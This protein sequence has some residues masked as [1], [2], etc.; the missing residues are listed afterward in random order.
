[1]EVFGGAAFLHKPACDLGLGGAS[2]SARERL[3]TL[4]RLG[5]ADVAFADSDYFN[6]WMATRFVAIWMTLLLDETGGDLDLAGA[7]TIAACG[8]PATRSVPRTCRW[9]I[10]CWRTSSG[11]R[12][13]LR[14]GTMLPTAAGSR[15]AVDRSA[16]APD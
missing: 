3:R 12:M 10:V 11:I 2:D 14:P 8:P 15:R 4:H 6:P 13:R 5:I 1:M 9:S 7:P 16:S